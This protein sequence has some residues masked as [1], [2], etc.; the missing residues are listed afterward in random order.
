MK[1][2]AVPKRKKLL[3]VF[4]SLLLMVR[5]L[6]TSKIAEFWNLKLDSTQEGWSMEFIQFPVKK[7][8]SYCIILYV[9]CGKKEQK[10]K[11]DQWQWNN[12]TTS[13]YNTLEHGF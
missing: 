4:F 12:E 3:C 10:E 6:L 7:I 9:V 2:N 1:K 8:Q 11:N 5:I 13:V